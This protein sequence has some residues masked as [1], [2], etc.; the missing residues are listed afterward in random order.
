MGAAC[1]LYVRRCVPGTV[2][3][4]ALEAATRLDSRRGGR[5]IHGSHDSRVD[6]LERR[7][8]EPVRGTSPASGSSHDAALR[9]VVL[10]GAN[11]DLGRRRSAAAARLRRSRWCSCR[12]LRASAESR[13][14]PRL[15][16]FPTGRASVLVDRPVERLGRVS[17]SR[18]S[19]RGLV[20]VR[21]PISGEGRL[22]RREQRHAPRL[23]LHAEPRRLRRP[24]GRRDSRRGWVAR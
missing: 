15:G 2:R 3:F 21:R 20:R 13:S 8:A 18:P 4:A 10:R 11:R 17:R 23:C 1:D 7:R 12:R 19:T 22:A 5:L 9:R 24:A 14:R 6:L 16:R